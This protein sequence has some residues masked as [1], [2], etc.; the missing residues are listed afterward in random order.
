MCKEDIRKEARSTDAMSLVKVKKK[1]LWNV[2]LYQSTNIISSPLKD[3][4]TG[5]VKLIEPNSCHKESSSL[6]VIVPPLYV[7]IGLDLNSKEK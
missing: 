4:P 7:E 5:F 2:F 6:C 1:M 3:I